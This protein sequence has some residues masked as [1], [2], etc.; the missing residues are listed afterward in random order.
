MSPA[1]RPLCWLQRAH[2]HSPRSAGRRPPTCRG[3]SCVSPAPPQLLDGG[4]GGLC[5][6]KQAPRQGCPFGGCAGAQKLGRAGAITLGGRGQPS[7]PTLTGP[8]WSRPRGAQQRPRR[9]LESHRLGPASRP[10]GEQACEPEARG[11]S[12]GPEAAAARRQVQAR[13]PV[14]PGPRLSKSRRRCQGDRRRKFPRR[15]PPLGQS[16]GRSQE[17]RF[18]LFRSHFRPRTGG[19]AAAAEGPSA[20]ASGMVWDRVGDER[21]RGPD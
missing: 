18:S 10:Q 17:P 4:A 8:F 2:P 9:L 6:V 16:D 12:A 20:G 1:Q 14:Q 13:R 5:G 3:P 7:S 19:S 21:V 11:R 15:A